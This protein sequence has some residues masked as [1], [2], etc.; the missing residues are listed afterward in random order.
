MFVSGCLHE[1]GDQ[2]SL[3]FALKMVES[4][5]TFFNTPVE[6]HLTWLLIEILIAI[7][8]NF[9]CYSS[10]ITSSQVHTACSEPNFAQ[11]VCVQTQ[12][13]AHQG[14]ELARFPGANAV[15]DTTLHLI[16]VQL[17]GRLP[18]CSQLYSYHGQINMNSFLIS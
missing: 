12:R 6:Q 13:S 10:Y 16:H 4:Q 11:A 3:G 17:S 5:A 9:A 2:V 14:H 1:S 8:F 18:A 15:L 7:R